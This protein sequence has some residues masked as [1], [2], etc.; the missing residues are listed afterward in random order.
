MNIKEFTLKTTHKTLELERCEQYPAKS[1]SDSR[2]Y[3]IQ[4]NQG[5][6]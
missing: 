3:Y 2:S 6:Q 1:H 5:L 4:P